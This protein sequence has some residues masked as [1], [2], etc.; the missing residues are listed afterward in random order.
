[1]WL[2]FPFQPLAKR[3][4]LKNQLKTKY[5]LVTHSNIAQIGINLIH[6]IAAVILKN[7]INNKEIMQSFSK[8]NNICSNTR[9]LL[10]T[11]RSV[12]LFH[13]LSKKKNLGKYIRK[14]KNNYKMHHGK[15]RQCK[16]LYK[17]TFWAILTNQKLLNNSF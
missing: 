12:I 4:K 16:L 1:M 6:K 15:I 14:K 3:N 13:K 7:G 5:Q 17:D 11:G 9:K 8:K 2:L 10:F